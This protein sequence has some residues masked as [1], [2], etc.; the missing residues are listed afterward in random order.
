MENTEIQALGIKY[1][2]YQI[3][4]PE[5]QLF[6][7]L[8]TC[9]LGVYQEGNFASLLDQPLPQST[10]PRRY[11]K[12]PKI[13]TVYFLDAL[14]HACKGMEPF[15]T[16]STR[17][18]QLIVQDMQGH[19]VDLD[20]DVV[21]FTKIKTMYYEILQENAKDEL[22]EKGFEIVI[23]EAIKIITKHMLEQLSVK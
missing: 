5:I 23:E 7:E 22:I 13:K 17:L 19:A 18:Y 11:E 15:L 16:I 6:L 21:F 8:P 14:F 1:F 4:R 20:L 9:D 12:I 10:Y 2:Y 3:Y